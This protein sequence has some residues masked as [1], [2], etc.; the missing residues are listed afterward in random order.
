MGYPD[1]VQVH[2]SSFFSGHDITYKTWPKGP[3]FSTSPRFEVAEISPGFRIGLWSYCSKGASVSHR[4]QHSELEFLLL[5]AAPSERHVEI[6]TMTAYY[7]GTR[8]LDLGHTFPIGEGWVAGSSLD[9]IL[10]CLP[11]P[12]GPGFENCDCGTKSVRILWLL[13]ITSREKELKVEQGIEALERKFDEARIEFWDP[14]RTG[15]V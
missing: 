11:Y 12:V 14:K 10:V 13:P 3:M 6:A 9:H 15:V 7:H 2:L 1:C 4:P 8:G 5:A